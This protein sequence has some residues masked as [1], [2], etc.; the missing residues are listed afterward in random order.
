[1]KREHFFRVVTLVLAYVHTF[2]ARRHIGEFLTQPSWL[3]GW[4]GFGALAAVFIYL[5]PP[6]EQARALRALW[7][8]QKTALRVAG[9]VL[10]V[11][12]LV[13]AFDHIPKFIEAPSFHDAWRGF[14]AGLAAVWFLIPLRAQMRIMVRTRALVVRCWPTVRETELPS[15]T[16]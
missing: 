1:V 13:P 14:G 15:L 11:V 8:R 9:A 5:L 16:E 7:N 10:S 12:H 2:P 6:L 4:K 3:E